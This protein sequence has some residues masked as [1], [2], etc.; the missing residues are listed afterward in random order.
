MCIIGVNYQYTI[1]AACAYNA[2]VFPKQP[3]CALIGACTLIRMNMVLYY[4]NIQ[5]QHI[6]YRSLLIADRS[7]GDKNYYCDYYTRGCISV[8][9]MGIQSIIESC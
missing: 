2:H 5:Y 8:I 3:G 4:T 6:R 9:F 7:G 1:Q